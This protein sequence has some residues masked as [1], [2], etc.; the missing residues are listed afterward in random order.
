M[1]LDRICNLE[2]DRV[3]RENGVKSYFGIF[4]IDNIP[5]SLLSG[6]QTFIVVCNLEKKGNFGSHFIV[7]VY[8][9]GHLLYL[10]SLAPVKEEIKSIF[11]KFNPLRLHT[12]KSPLQSINS[13]ACG[14][15][16]LFFVL[17]F[18][19]VLC[20]K[21]VDFIFPFSQNKQDGNDAIC[22]K[23]ITMIDRLNKTH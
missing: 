4:S 2:I 1:K 15:Y 12:L 21:P 8:H 17:Y 10:D 13:Q 6:K 14:Y 16:C 5:F 19:R 7:L 3:I 9:L 22:L 23:N 20:N 18:D 11:F